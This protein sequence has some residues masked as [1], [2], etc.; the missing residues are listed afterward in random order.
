MLLRRESKCQR[1][2][3]F[4]LIE[5]LVVVAIIVAL[6]S[7]GVFALMPMLTGGQKDAAKT[8]IK[9]LTGACQAYAAKHGSFPETLDVLT[10]KDEQGYGPYVE[11]D[12]IFDPWS[13]PANQRKYNYAKEGPKN[14]GVK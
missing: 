6:A 7:V 1:R 14:N 5:M 4:T 2:A 8:Q 3:G 10:V 12:A 11:P 9:G 13:T